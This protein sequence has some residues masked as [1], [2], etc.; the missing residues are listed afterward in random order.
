MAHVSLM[1]FVVPRRLLVRSPHPQSS[2]LAVVGGSDFEEAA[3]SD[4]PNL[5]MTFLVTYV[6]LVSIMLLNLLIAMMYG[7]PW[8]W[9]LGGGGGGGGCVCAA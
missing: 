6:V 9:C 4:H 5:Y 7:H 8:G 1:L 2:F 3:G